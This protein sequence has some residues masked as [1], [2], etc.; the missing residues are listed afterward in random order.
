M[1]AWMLSLVLLGTPSPATEEQFI[2]VQAQVENGTLLFSQGDCLAVR[3]Y[4]LSSYTH[5]GIVVLRGTEPWVYDS[6][7][8]QGVRKMP[9]EDYLSEQVPSRLQMVHPQSPLSDTQVACMTKHLEQELGR[10][11]GILHHA[12]GHRSDGLHC[13]EYVTDALIE[14]RLMTARQPSRVSPGSLLQGVMGGKVYRTGE[15]FEFCE[16]PLLPPES[17]TW[18]Q[19]SCR[20]TRACCTAAC[21][22]MSRWLLCREK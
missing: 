22:Q 20:Q 8:G 6:M 5:V 1:S 2:R 13:A 9:L 17:E 18:C 11:Y 15:T 16:A 14:A 21:R 12:T 4:S 3:I 19:Q 10:P 7:N